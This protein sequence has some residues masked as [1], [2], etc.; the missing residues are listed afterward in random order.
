MDRPS[1]SKPKDSKN[2]VFKMCPL[3]NHLVFLDSVFLLKKIE[4]IKPVS[5]IVRR[6]RDHTHKMPSTHLM[7]MNMVRHHG[8][9]V[10]TK[11]LS[12]DPS[13]SNPIVI[14]L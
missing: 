14:V 12:V 10:S 3:T 5:R 7:L 1:A 11:M 13:S 6:I 9:V 4:T 2:F 8:T